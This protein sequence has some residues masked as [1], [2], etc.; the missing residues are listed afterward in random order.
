MDEKEEKIAR[1]RAALEAKNAC[2]DMASGEDTTAASAE[3]ESTPEEYAEAIALKIV[4]HATIRQAVRV[5]MPG[6]PARQAMVDVLIP[7]ALRH[8]LTVLF[9]GGDVSDKALTWT[10]KPRSKL[11]GF[12]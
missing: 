11:I 6:L 8:V 4:K 1:I 3:A 2:T 7:E 10:P 9:T 12:K 5:K